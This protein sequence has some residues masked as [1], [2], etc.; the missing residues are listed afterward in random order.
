M[1]PGWISEDDVEAAVPAALGV[2]GFGA[3]R[4]RG[5][6]LGEREVP[7]EQPV[8]AGEILDSGARGSRGL[9][10]VLADL[11]GE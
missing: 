4:W 3:G 6:H 9:V 2:V 1:V 8:G 5:Q 11:G 7:V 10:R